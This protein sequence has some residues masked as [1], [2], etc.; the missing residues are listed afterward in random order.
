MNNCVIPPVIEKY[1]QLLASKNS[2]LKTKAIQVISADAKVGSLDFWDDVA[3]WIK[4]LIKAANFLLHVHDNLIP[5]DIEIPLGKINDKPNNYVISTYLNEFARLQVECDAVILREKF[6]QLRYVDDFGDVR[7]EKW[8]GYV[9]K[10]VSERI[11]D[12]YYESAR[13]YCELDWLHRLHIGP[14]AANHIAAIVARD[15][16]VNVP[17]VEDPYVFE[18]NCASLLEEAGWQCRLS[19]KSGDQGVDIVVQ[20][21]NIKVAVQCKLYN[22]NVGNGAVQEVH[23]GMFF[24]GCDAAIVVSN[25]GFT[26]SARQ[27]AES[28]GIHL[29][30]PDRLE[31]VA[32]VLCEQLERERNI[33]LQEP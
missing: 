2:D 27:L 10:Y 7:F 4:D 32:N 9:N 33:R 17:L 14:V 26:I 20:K 12:K 31:G 29:T 30:S 23:A 6:R 1:L 13:K 15:I 5:I 21:R 19:G 11:A 24:Y 22:S 28:L 8:Y 16:S 25:A 18:R 3:Y